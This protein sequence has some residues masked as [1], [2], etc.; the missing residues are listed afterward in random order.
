V[1]TR[2]R[3]QLFLAQ[4]LLSLSL[5]VN[6]LGEVL[7]LGTP[8]AQQTRSADDLDNL[9]GYKKMRLGLPLT[10]AFGRFVFCSM[11]IAQVVVETMSSTMAWRT[12]G[13]LG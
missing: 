10:L 11:G 6:T 1:T 13:M 7:K 9:P 8:A 5:M 4:K 12:A 2:S 3:E